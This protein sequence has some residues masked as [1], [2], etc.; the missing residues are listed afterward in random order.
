MKKTNQ[1]QIKF[2]KE[3]SI[4]NQIDSESLELYCQI[5]SDRYGSLNDQEE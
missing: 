2:F 3:E 5:M 4:F 1:I